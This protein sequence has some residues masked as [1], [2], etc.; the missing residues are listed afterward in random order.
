MQIFFH[1]NSNMRILFLFGGGYNEGCTFGSRL[2]FQANA[3]GT[4]PN[5]GAAITHIIINIS[6]SS[7]PSTSSTA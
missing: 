5:V 2:A 7:K 3:S 6:F 1:L 4:S